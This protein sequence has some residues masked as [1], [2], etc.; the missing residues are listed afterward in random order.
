[1]EHCC[2]LTEHANITLNLLSE[3]HM[4]PSLFTHKALTGAF[5]FDSV[6]PQG[7]KCLVHV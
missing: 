1:M 6:T 4:N 2:Q 7:A 3:C 5:H